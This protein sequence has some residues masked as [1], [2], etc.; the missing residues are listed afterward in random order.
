VRREQVSSTDRQATA[1]MKSVLY[2]IV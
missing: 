1:R 2:T